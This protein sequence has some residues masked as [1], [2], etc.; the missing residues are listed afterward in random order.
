[1]MQGMG[2]DAI[3]ISP[4]VAQVADASRGYHGYSAQDLYAVNQNF[5]TED[6]LK[7]LASVLHDRGM[8]R[9]YYSKITSFE[10]LI[11]K[12]QYLM[13]D[14]VANHMASDDDASVVDYSVI[15]PFNERGYYHDICWI[16]DYTNQTNVENARQLSYTALSKFL[17]LIILVLARKR[18]IPTPRS[19]H[20]TDIRK[21]S[22]QYMD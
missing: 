14:I 9:N 8:V 12:C 19:Q 17:M 2:F 4:V 5:G 22:V 15:N 13:V 3:W 7:D 16:T 10:F 1:M 6:E 21:R 11:V 18:A 20:S